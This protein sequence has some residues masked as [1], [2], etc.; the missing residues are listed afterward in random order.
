MPRFC[1]CPFGPHKE[2]LRIGGFVESRSNGTGIRARR[3]NAFEQVEIGYKI[4]TEKGEF[5]LIIYKLNRLY[6]PNYRS[7]RILTL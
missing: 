7:L 3:Q 6:Q 4:E 2:F 5:V 1:Y